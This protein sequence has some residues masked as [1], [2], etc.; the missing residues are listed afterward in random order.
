M[1]E[2]R[3]RAGKLALFRYVSVYRGHLNF[4]REWFEGGEARNGQQKCPAT[5]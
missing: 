5:S 3:D 1:D 2:K 4:L